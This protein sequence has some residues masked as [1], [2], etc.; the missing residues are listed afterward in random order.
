MF[1]RISGGEAR[2]THSTRLP[3]VLNE[4]GKGRRREKYYEREDEDLETKSGTAAGGMDRE[5]ASV[6]K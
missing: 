1:K 3:L 5:S 6:Y 2:H 4:N